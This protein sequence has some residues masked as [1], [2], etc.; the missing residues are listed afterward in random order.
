M[1]RA[2]LDGAKTQTRRV[3]RFRHESECHELRDDVKP[4]GNKW[5]FACG[6]DQA[7][8]DN[9]F[10]CVVACP[11][12]QPGNRLWVRETWA[13]H[14]ALYDD[15][16]PSGIHGSVK[17]GAWE[18]G[19]SIWYRATH[20]HRPATGSCAPEQRGKWRPSIYMP[21]WASRITLEVESVRVER[22]QEITTADIRAEGVDDGYTNPR[23]GKRHDN[24]MRMAWEELWDSINAKRGYGWESNPWVWVITFQMLKAGEE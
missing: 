18:E 16:A 7:R 19:D 3:I 21:R 4:I 10:S 24:G 14:G 12:G 11:Y 13:V 15:L 6:G 5:L 23:M 20:P 8:E 1:V 17:G 9:T 22:V 2:I